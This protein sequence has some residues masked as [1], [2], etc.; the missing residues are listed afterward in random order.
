MEEGLKDIGSLVAPGKYDLEE[1]CRQLSVKVGKLQQCVLDKKKADQLHMENLAAEQENARQRL[2][3]NQRDYE[4]F[5]R[6]S[7]EMLQEIENLRAISLRD[8][9][10]DV[11]NRRAY[12]SQIVKTLHAYKNGALKTCSLVVFDIDNFRDFNNTYGHL[13]GRRPGPV[14]CGQADPRYPPPR[15]PDFSLRRG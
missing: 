3:S 14:L 4:D 8:P 1:L 12:D 15:R 2:V 11:Y 5:N 13:P 10:T 9:L 7:H 6:Q